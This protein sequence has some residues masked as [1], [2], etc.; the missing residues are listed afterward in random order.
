MAEYAPAA[1]R[2]LYDRIKVAYP[3]AQLSGIV[4]NPI[5]HTRGYHR[6]RNWIRN[7]GSGSDYSVQ[8]ADDLVGDGDAASAL[9]ITLPPADMARMSQRLLDLGYA[10]DP[11]VQVLREFFGTVDSRRVIGLDFRDVRAVTSDASHLWH[12]HVSVLRRY[13]TDANALNQV[14]AAIV[15]GT[16]PPP[17]TEDELER[18]M[19]WYPDKATYEAA[20]KKMVRDMVL[21]VLRKEGIPGNAAAAAQ[22]AGNTANVVLQVVRSEAIPGNAAA[23]AQR[24][25]AILDKLEG[26]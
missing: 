23:A 9:D 8:R 1:I 26:S 19:A 22:R 3:A 17:T 14:A 16:A 11:R 13:A 20:L 15:G 25:Q 18:I 10:R 2:G 24:A 12:V 7:Y 4:G 21:E 6:S 5:T